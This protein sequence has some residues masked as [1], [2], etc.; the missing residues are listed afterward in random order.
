[1]LTSHNRRQDTVCHIDTEFYNRNFTIHPV[2]FGGVREDDDTRL[3]VIHPGAEDVLEMARKD[4]ESFITDVIFSPQVLD[5]GNPVRPST[6]AEYNSMIVD[7]M[8]VSPEWWIFVGNYDVVCM[9]Q[10]FGG[11][12]KAP[13]HW[14]RT[15]KELSVLCNMLGISIKEHYPRNP[16][17]NP[18]GPHHNGL[19][20]ALWG[21]HVYRDI[22][23]RCSSGEFG[24][25]GLSVIDY[26]TYKIPNPG[27]RKE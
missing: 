11:M 10:T 6:D 7:F 9:H 18:Y 4:N 12:M 15:Y 17:D 5:W 2:S 27:D 20:D 16:P 22:M 21:Q 8:G 24:T 1:M 25:L 14:K 23:R 19:A 13:P 3:Y 26:V